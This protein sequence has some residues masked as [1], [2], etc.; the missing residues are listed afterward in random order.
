MRL[1]RKKSEPKQ[2]AAHRRDKSRTPTWD[3]C[4]AQTV[5]AVTACLLLEQNHLCAYC[6]RRIGKTEPNGLQ[7]EHISPQRST[8]QFGLAWD[9]LVAVCKGLS[10]SKS[11]PAQGAARHCDSSKGHRTISISP[12]SLNDISK[13]TCGR[14]SGRILS[15]DDSA[16]EDIDK[17]LNLNCHLLT[18]VRK[19]FIEGLVSGLTRKLG[20]GTWKKKDLDAALAAWRT[21]D[22]KGYLPEFVF[23]AEA[24]LAKRT[25]RGRA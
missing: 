16:Q 24:V 7:V 12:L 22:N 13:I 8:P 14:G 15:S 5:A 10:V 9:N 19:G 23:I 1:I 2:L 11:P 4:P 20:K 21:P 3:N 18:S 17:T 6:V 25:R